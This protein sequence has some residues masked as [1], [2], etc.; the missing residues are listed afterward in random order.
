MDENNPQLHW[1]EAEKVA[2]IFEKALTPEADIQ[3]NQRLP[4]RVTGDLRQCDVVIRYG[5]PP[6]Q[7]T[8][9]VEVQHRS[10]RPPISDYEGWVAKKDA[11][12]AN[13]LICVSQHGFPESVIRA[14]R[15]RHANAV[16]LVTMAE[17]E[18]SRWPEFLAFRSI[19]VR[20][21]AYTVISANPVL[22]PNHRPSKLHAAFA[23]TDRVW[24]V[25]GADG[26]LTVNDVV[27][28]TRDLD[29]AAAQLADG[30]HEVSFTLTLP[31]LGLLLGDR[32]PVEEARIKALL[33]ITTQVF[34][35]TAIEYREPDAGG[36]SPVM[37]CLQAQINGEPFDVRQTI[38]FDN[39][40][41]EFRIH[42]ETLR[43]PAGMGPI[44]WNFL[45]VLV[46]EVRPTTGT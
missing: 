11:L 38:V 41:R 6:R 36:D 12:G 23:L 19:P 46:P 17:L 30:E 32:V 5:S 44:S 40:T 7:M 35:P 18:S 13:L 42:T 14:A 28:M 37:I 29:T 10:R 3:V 26:T 20:H 39:A 27:N 4:D 31:R 8:A 16:R 15:T 33:S 25:S 2:A 22:S 9:I 43:S 21:T 1:K 24:F 45:G 34:L